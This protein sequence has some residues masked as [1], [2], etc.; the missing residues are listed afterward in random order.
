MEQIQQIENNIHQIRLKLQTHPLYQNLNTI[1]DIRIFMENH[2]FAVWDFMTLL[3]SLQN[4]L[5]NV[6]VP[7][8]PPKNP[9]LARFINEIVQ[10]EESD[11]NELGEPKSHFEMYLDAMTQL[12]ANQHHIQ[13]FLELVA[14]GNNV[15]FALNEIEV[16][17]GIVDFV[18][19]TFTIV[20]TQKPHLIAAAFTFG[21]E[22]VIPDM[23]I[24]ILKNADANNEKFNKLKYYLERHIELDGD[25]HGP[26]S[27][28]MV[29]E[30]CGN[31][32]NKWKEAN[33][34]ALLSL[35]KR[36]ALWNGINDLI[37]KKSKTTAFSH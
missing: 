12:N 34:V 24:E 29:S 6:Q 33:D 14:A 21:R 19:F 16:D 10:G 11:I 25:E 26:L 23:F 35:E 8:T 4:H 36:I 2:I 37:L 20:K 3:K 13:K 22:D 30:L 5:T 7:W 1:E 17:K 15:N 31:D 28:R 27:L 9:V 18:K 32:Q